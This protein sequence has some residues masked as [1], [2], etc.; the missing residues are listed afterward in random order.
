MAQGKGDV[1][2][3]N[4]LGGLTS[5]LRLL[6]LAVEDSS[7]TQAQGQ[8]LG[9]YLTVQQSRVLQV[10]TRLD[11]A[12]KELDEATVK[13]RVMTAQLARIETELPRTADPSRRGA[14]ES[15]ERSLRQERDQ[16]AIQEQQARAREGELS[17]AMQLEDSRWT[18]LVSSLERLIKK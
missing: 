1:V 15:E 18:D 8:A 7:R 9:V 11:L 16:V 4:T 5:E 10:T 17:Q 2:D 13:L 12:R 14:L 6:R 3:P